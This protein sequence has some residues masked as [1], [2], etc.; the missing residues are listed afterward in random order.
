MDFLPLVR[1][2]LGAVA[3][4]L[5]AG[6]NAPQRNHAMPPAPA[7]PRMNVP[8]SDVYDTPVPSPAPPAQPDAP[9][10]RQ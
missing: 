5:I 3:A 4:G 1:W 6:C 2:S 9:R 8:A 10:Q 7:P